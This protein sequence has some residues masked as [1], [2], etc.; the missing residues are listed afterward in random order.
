MKLIEMAQY[1]G[2]EQHLEKIIKF[3]NDDDHIVK[4]K[5]H[6]DNKIK[7]I[8]SASFFDQDHIDQYYTPEDEQVPFVAVTFHGYEDSDIYDPGEFAE[9]AQ[10]FELKRVM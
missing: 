6:Y 9:D 1:H 3:C 2:R 7:L 4:I 10:V 8:E 5:H